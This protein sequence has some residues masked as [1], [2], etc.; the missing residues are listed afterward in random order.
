MTPAG[1]PHSEISGSKPVNDSPKLIAA[2]RVLHRLPMPRHPPLALSSLS[3]NLIKLLRDLNYCNLRAWGYR[4]LHVRWSDKDR[5][6]MADTGSKDFFLLYYSIIKDR[7]CFR[8]YVLRS[9]FNQRLENTTQYVDEPAKY[10][11]WWR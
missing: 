10:K 4:T 11:K 3:T 2:C 8:H 1:L 5:C 6:T 7:F 9:A